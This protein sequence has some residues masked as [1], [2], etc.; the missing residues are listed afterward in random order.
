MAYRDFTQLPIWKNGFELLLRLYKLSQNFPTEERY[1]LTSDM[2]RGANSLIHNIAE[3][4]GRYEKRDKTRFYKIAR[5]C[6]YELI[7]QLYTCE[8]LA[9]I[10][11]QHRDELIN[12]YVHVIL[13]INKL[14]RSVESR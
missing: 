1:G 9:Y 6:A 10:E 14:I 2:R 11:I 8:A 4:F 13:E 3:G 7:S 12:G 5:G